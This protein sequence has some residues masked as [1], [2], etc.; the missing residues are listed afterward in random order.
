MGKICE[1]LAHNGPFELLSRQAWVTGA[2]IFEAIEQHLLIVSTLLCGTALAS[3]FSW[4]RSK[5]FYGLIATIS[6]FVYLLTPNI[7]LK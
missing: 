2:P 6:M 3:R 1:K 5:W 4:K 7:D